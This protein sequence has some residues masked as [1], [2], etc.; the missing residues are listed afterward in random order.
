MTR[1]LATAVLSKHNKKIN[2]TFSGLSGI[3]N[4]NQYI[5]QAKRMNSKRWQELLKRHKKAD[6]MVSKS[7]L[8]VEAMQE[9]I[10]IIERKVIDNREPWKVW[11][12]HVDIIM[13]VLWS[14]MS[15]CDK[16]EDVEDFGKEY[17]EVFREFL[18][19]GAYA[20]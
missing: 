7:V 9:F 12:K 13:I 10:E 18:E 4:N 15:D 14:S 6:K 20:N 16:W 11:H 5:G 8:E 1:K 2:Y 19:L 17:E 3:T